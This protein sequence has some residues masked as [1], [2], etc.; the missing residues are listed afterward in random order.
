MITYDPFW[1]T[2]KENKISTYA[3]IKKYNISSSLIHRLRHNLPINTVT[4]NDLC[5]ILKCDVENVLCFKPD[6]NN[7]DECLKR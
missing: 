2:L 4:I 5:T 7:S 6:D 3:L 1:G